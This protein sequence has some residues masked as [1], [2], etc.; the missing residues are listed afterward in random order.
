MADESMADRAPVISID[1]KRPRPM[2]SRPDRTILNVPVNR[3]TVLKLLG[4]GAVSLALKK[5]ADWTTNDALVTEDQAEKMAKYPPTHLW[6]GTA[7]FEISNNMDLL[8]DPI[9]DSAYA[10]SQVLKMGGKPVKTGDTVVL[11]N[12]LIVERETDSGMKT[13]WI[14]IPNL[15][16]RNLGVRNDILGYAPLNRGNETF[17]SSYKIT[18]VKNGHYEL[19]G[20]DPVP[21]NQTQVFKVNGK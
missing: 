6:I 9:N 10:V 15:E 18:G 11:Q 1:R 2:V 21:V 20:H 13:E 14:P 7:K 4:A 12:P 19:E 5:S 3:R 16:R 17:G 8:T